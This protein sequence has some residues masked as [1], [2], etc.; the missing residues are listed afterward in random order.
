MNGVSGEYSLSKDSRLVVAMLEFLRI[1]I[2]PN[3]RWENEVKN[4]KIERE[5]DVYRQL[6]SE[7]SSL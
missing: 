4:L 2:H 6:H 5:N 3:N 1:H 7:V